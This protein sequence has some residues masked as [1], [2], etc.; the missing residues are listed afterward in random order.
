MPAYH[1]CIPGAMLGKSGVEKGSKRPTAKAPTSTEILQYCRYSSVRWRR[2]RSA[3]L[4][5]TVTSSDG[6]C[7]WALA[8]GT[9]DASMRSIPVVIVLGSVREISAISVPTF[10]FFVPSLTYPS[11]RRQDAVACG[12]SP[13]EESIEFWFLVF[14]RLPKEGTR[15]PKGVPKK[16]G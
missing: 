10:F 1:A 12:L 2:T 7:S 16:G 13:N 6:R 9:G 8:F 14:R 5:Y 11:N 4:P 15:R 3:L